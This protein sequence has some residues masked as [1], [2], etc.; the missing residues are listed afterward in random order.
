M[1]G[2]CTWTGVVADPQFSVAPS[3]WEVGAATFPLLTQDPTAAV[4]PGMLDPGLVRTVKS[5]FMPGHMTCDEYEGPISQS[6]ML[7]RLSRAEPL[8]ALVN[9][10]YTFQQ[11]MPP[12]DGAIG[13]GPLWDEHVWN[14]P[15]GSGPGVGGWQKLRQCLGAAQYAPES[16]SGAGATLPVGLSFTYDQCQAPPTYEVDYD[17]FEIVPANAHECPDPGTALNGDAEANYGWTFT[18]SGTGASAGYMAGAGNNSTQGIALAIGTAC[19]SYGSASVPVSVPMRDTTGSPMLSVWHARPVAAGATTLQIDDN[20]VSLSGFSL[21]GGV[22]HWCLP[23]SLQGGVFTLTAALASGASCIAGTSIFDDVTVTNDPGCG[24]DPY[25][26]NAG[27]ESALSRLMNVSTS[28]G[29]V[30]VV[31][32]QNNHYLELALTKTCGYANYRTDVVTPP[33]TAGVTG[34][35]VRFTYQFTGGSATYFTVASSA[36]MPTQQGWHSMTAC[37]DKSRAAGR[38]QPLVIALQNVANTCG[39]ALTNVT[40]DIDDLQIVA[41]PSCK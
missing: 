40:A 6:V 38:A 36:T 14:L 16:G 9:V 37:L 7:P 26:T 20:V 30:S 19:G 12:L 10:G 18:S 32:P 25:V 33:F 22:D 13:I 34:P 15:G 39:T 27:F 8:V 23:A 2:T 41:D 31:A 24:T 3:P 5:N 17:H 35:A 21:P 28:D 4:G 1:A 29:T 11:Q